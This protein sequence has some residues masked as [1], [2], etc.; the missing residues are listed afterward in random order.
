MIKTRLVSI[1]YGQSKLKMRVALGSEI[2]NT[3]TEPI[4]IYKGKT[5]TGTPIVL[6]AGAKWIV[7]AGYSIL[8]I[9]NT[10]ATIFA[11]LSI[12]PPIV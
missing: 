5:I 8:S 7:I 9:E 2:T 11:K 10:S 3:G 4:N 1:A 12:L 6:A